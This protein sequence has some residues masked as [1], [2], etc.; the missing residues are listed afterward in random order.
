MDGDTWTQVESTKFDRSASSLVRLG[1]RVFVIDGHGET[2]VEEFH[3]NNN[4]WST[5]DATTM[6]NRNGHHKAISLPAEL[7][8]HLP[9]GCFGVQ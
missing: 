8:N 2:A 9:G 1:N 6:G 7:F 4:T 3:V 5:I